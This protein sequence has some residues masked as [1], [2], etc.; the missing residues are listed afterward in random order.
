[1]VSK[2][3]FL[4]RQGLNHF[5][6][7]RNQAVIACF[8]LTFF[9]TLFLLIS[10]GKPSQPT[11]NQ[12][13]FSIN[14]SAGLS[15]LD[16]AFARDQANQWMVEQL[17]TGLITLDSALKPIPAL[18]TSWEISD[19]GRIY[20]F[21]LRKDVF[22][23]DN[24]CFSEGKGK[25]CTAKDIVYSFTRI[26]N[27]NLASP[28]FWIFNGKVQGAT[29]FHEGKAESVSGFLVENDSTVVIKLNSPFP[30]FLLQ[31]G[32]QYCGIVPKE[33]IEY[34]GEKFSEHPVG[35]GPFTFGF[36]YPGEILALRRNPK[37]FETENGR[38]LPFLEG[39]KVRFIASPLSAYVEFKRG[40]ID[41]ISRLDPSFKEEVFDRKGNVLPSFSKEYKVVS[42]PQL[43]TEYL[44]ILLDS[45]K[46]LAMESP[47]SNSKVRQAFSSAID[48]KKMV[49][50]LLGGMGKAANAGMVPPGLPS[51]DEQ[52]VKG[53]VYNPIKAAQLLSEAGYPKGINLPELTLYSSPVYQPVMEFIQK[54]VSSVGFKV[55][56]DNGEGAALRRRIG[57]GELNLWRASWIADYPDPENYLALFYSK[58]KAPDGPNTTRFSSKQFDELYEKAMLITDFK[59]R[60]E[61]YK[62]LDQ[63]VM[64]EMPV[65][66]L[67]YD[68]VV[69]LMRKNV[70]GLES[71]ALNMLVLK[72]VKKS[73]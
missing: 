51:Y 40:N 64:D 56:I 43:N 62:Q 15:S 57:A 50:Y 2:T 58:N 10:C 37:Y 32:M 22:F 13:V 65:I 55:K 3:L 46:E 18:A 20:R 54:E 44:G 47:L 73:E 4:K 6:K 69:R 39:I 27:Q 72:K 41:F 26:C 1:M 71:N 23:H 17:F 49:K 52:K 36:W 28:A 63:M 16:P 7:I 66:P 12:K 42:Y 35:T 21:N 19:S 70:S 31:L 33:A 60:N 8:N 38:Q 67:Y 5:S 29:E 68:R 24:P 25:K 59:E 45:T 53:Y 11:E 14:L 30:P 34:Y 48:R 9:C 61:V